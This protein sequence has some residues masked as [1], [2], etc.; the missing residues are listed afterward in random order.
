MAFICCFCIFQVQEF[1]LLFFKANNYI[2]VAIYFSF[3]AITFSLVFENLTKL[4]HFA[5]SFH[6]HFHLPPA[7][8]VHPHEQIKATRMRMHVHRYVC[9]CA[10]V[11]MCVC[12]DVFACVYL[13]MFEQV[14][15]CMFS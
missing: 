1:H 15:A 5:L 2:Q 3:M 10:Y 11:Y 7:M 8:A 6:P 12:L 4:F 9:L 13:C 14:R